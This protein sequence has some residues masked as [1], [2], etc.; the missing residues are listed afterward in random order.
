MARMK[1]RTLTDG[2]LEFM[3]VLWADSAAAPD[4]IQKALAERGRMVTGG[5]IR[6]ILATLVGKGYVTRE[7]RGKA[8][9]YRAKVA[10]GQ[11]K[12]S[13]VQ[14]LLERAFGGSE[15]HLMASLLENREMPHEEITRI[16]HLIAVQEIKE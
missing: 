15:S 5:T 9:Y 6:N 1:S 12:R 11:A 16:K 3:L 13:M 8:Y 10:E 14:D 7:K 2:E 4:D